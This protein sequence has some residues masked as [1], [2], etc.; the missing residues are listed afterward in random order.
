MRL[1]ENNKATSEASLRLRRKAQRGNPKFKDLLLLDLPLCILPKRGN[2]LRSLLL[3][4]LFLFILPYI[5]LAQ[6]RKQ[7]PSIE[8]IRDDITQILETVS[9][10]TDAAFNLDAFLEQ[11]VDLYQKP[12]NLN[13]ASYED[14]TNLRLLSP[15]QADAVVRH[16]EQFGNFISIYE[17]QAVEYMDVDAITRMLPFVTVRSDIDDYQIQSIKQLLFEGDF[18][19]YLR[20]SQILEE[21]DGY[22][23]LDS[24]ETGTRYAGNPSRFYTRFRYN[25]PNKLSYGF[26]A[27][28]DAGEEFFHDTQP[29]GYDFYS[30][31]LFVRNASIFKSI[32]VGDFEAKFGQGLIMWSGFGFGKSPFVTNIKK[33]SEALK[34]Y[35]SVDENNFLRGI[36]TTI[37]AGNFEITGFFSQDRKDANI[38]LLVDT[39]EDDFISQATSL[40]E[41]GLHRTESE[42]EDKD[43]AKQLITGGHIKFQKRASHLALTATHT[44]LDFP[45]SANTSPYN[46]FQFSGDR[47]TNFGMDYA[48]LIKNFYFFGE[49]ALR[50]NWSV[51]M[52]YGF[53]ASLDPK[54]DISV[55]YRY[56]QKDYFSF[57]ANPFGESRNPF[58]EQGIYA[59]ISLKP[60]KKIQLDTYIDYFKFPWLRYQ[61]DAPSNGIDFLAQLTWKP[62]K[63]I[64]L[65]GRYKNETKQENEPGNTSKLDVLADVNK[66]NIR[67]NARYKVSESITLENRFEYV[68][69]NDGE[70]ENGYLIFQ[71]ITYS[72]LGFPLSV[73]ARFALFD[74]KSYDSR[75]YAYEDDVLYSYSIPG[76]YNKGTRFYLVLSYKATRNIDLWLRFAQAYVSN[77]VTIGSG[78]DEIDGNVRNEIRGQVRFKF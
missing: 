23:P 38:E 45:L 37:E 61:V 14:L 69:F 56:Y 24:G 44:R 35:T 19:L 31:H 77:Q 48:L 76:F 71:D 72:A 4:L 39:L 18:E 62:T 9:E 32:A 46:Q 55:A 42:L 41:S 15:E 43:A 10:E 59:G 25:F 68:I 16:R 6:E 52:L 22:V 3:Y 50:N 13:R 7:K 57:F 20:Y 58:N 5:S 36:G 53:I 34:P 65:Y 64:E 70:K 40:Q 78:L 60:F 54:V 73:S 17:L 29:R 26:T 30:G 47:L 66:Q 75:V 1:R 21:Q 27:E 33:S 63:K 49:V 12:M 11:L 2:D 51:A 8:E 74:T 28:K 67:F